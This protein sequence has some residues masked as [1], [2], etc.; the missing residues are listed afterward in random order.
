VP[1]GLVVDAD[2]VSH[3]RDVVEVA[4]DLDRVRDV[5]VT[6]PDG[7]QGVDVSLV[8]LGREVGQLDCEVAERTLTR[9]EPRLP[10]VVYRVVCG[11]VVCALGT[12]VVGMCRR[13]VAAGLLGGGHRREQLTL[14]P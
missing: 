13:S 5:A 9:R 10:V 2:A 1:L 11:L 7:P 8:D 6:Q 3:T 12:E 4:D 14:L